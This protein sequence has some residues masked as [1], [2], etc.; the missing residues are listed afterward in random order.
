MKCTQKNCKEIIRIFA[1][2]GFYHGPHHY[3]FARAVCLKCGE[4]PIWPWHKISS[5]NPALESE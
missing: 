3:R 4:M 1:I 5:L 2:A